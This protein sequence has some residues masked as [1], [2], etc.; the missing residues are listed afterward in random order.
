[1]ALDALNALAQ[2]SNTNLRS[3]AQLIQSLANVVLG[4]TDPN[5]PAS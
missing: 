1:M 4:P 3:Q 5:A 2:S